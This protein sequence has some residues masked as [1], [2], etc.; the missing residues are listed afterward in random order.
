MRASL[1]G[2]NSLSSQESF[3]NFVSFANFVKF[4]AVAQTQV[5]VCGKLPQRRRPDSRRHRTSAEGYSMSLHMDV[6]HIYHKGR[7]AHEGP[8]QNPLP[9]FE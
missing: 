5:I 6:G 8:L 4:V 7:K 3:V 9:V 2:R 1:D